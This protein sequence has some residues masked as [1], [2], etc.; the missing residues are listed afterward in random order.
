MSK[1]FDVWWDFCLDRVV[2][3][4]FR[5]SKEIGNKECCATQDSSLDMTVSVARQIACELLKAAD[6]LEVAQVQCGK[7]LKRL[8][9]NN[10]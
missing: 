9:K 6:E 4:T 3:T 5:Y 1:Y 2:L 8:D 7:D 10:G